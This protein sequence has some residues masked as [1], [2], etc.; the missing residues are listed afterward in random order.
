ME[1]CLFRRGRPFGTI[2]KVCLTYFGGVIRSI[3][4]ISGKVFWRYLGFV[5]EVFWR[6]ADAEAFNKL[7]VFDCIFL[8]I[9]VGLLCNSCGIAVGILWECCGNAVGLLWY[10]CGIVVVGLL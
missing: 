8:G 9:T 6:S 4:V 2:L 5:L 7:R 3:F 1:V 10:C